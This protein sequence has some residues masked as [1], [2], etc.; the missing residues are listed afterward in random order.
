MRYLCYYLISIS[1]L[2]FRAED[3]IPSVKDVRSVIED[4]ASIRFSKINKIIDEIAPGNIILNLNNIA[5]KELEMIRPFIL[6][7]FSGKLELLNVGN[8]SDGGVNIL[9]G[10]GNSSSAQNFI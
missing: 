5:S 3:D 10:F 2:I 8:V 7:A 4:I 9:N 1:F 6:E